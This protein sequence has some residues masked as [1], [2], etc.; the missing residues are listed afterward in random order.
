[1]TTADS[2]KASLPGIESNV[3]ELAEK[4]K[5]LSAAARIEAAVAHFGERLALSTSFGIQSA[6]MLHLA[7]QVKP[8]LPIVFIDTGYLFPE[9]YRFAEDLRERLS[10]N[11][12]VYQPQMSAARFEA[13]HGKLW[14]GGEEELRAYGLA[15]KVEPMNRALR[16]LN[17]GAWMSGLRQSQASTREKLQVVEKQNRTW[18][19]HPILEWSD[20]DVYHYLNAHNLPYHPLWEKGYV[21]VG[22]WHSTRPLSEGTTAEQT[23]FNGIKRECGLHETSGEPEYQ[24]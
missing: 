18:K 13:L 9:T 21:S 7:T 22:D 23:R 1:M 20:R 4:L 11:L 15:H 3:P 10:L 17:A 24:I 6:V 19:I 2:K 16:E 5:P 14:E 12:K 8:D